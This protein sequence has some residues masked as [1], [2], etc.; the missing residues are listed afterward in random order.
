MTSE[1]I[2]SYVKF[3]DELVSSKTGKG[4]KDIEKAIIQQIL[5][6]KRLKE[7]SFPGYTSGTIQQEF[8]Y[9]LWKLLSVVTGQKVTMKT[10]PFVLEKLQKQQLAEPSQTFHPL[11]STVNIHNPCKSGVIEINQP[12]MN[13][14]HD[15][16]E[17]PDVPVFYGRTDELTTLEEWIITDKCKLV[18]LLGMG[19]IGKTSLSRKLVDKLIESSNEFQCIIWRSLRESPPIEKILTD[20]IKFLS[21][22]QITNLPDSLDEKITLLITC[23]NSSRCLL[24]LDN[25]ESILQIGNQSGQYRE[26]YQGY[27]Q[28]LSRVGESRHQSC[29]L[30][31]SREK[32]IEITTIEGVNRPIRSLQVAGLQN[33]ARQ[34]IREKSLYGSEE[35]IYK[36]TEI[37]SGNPLALNLAANAIKDLF[38]GNITECILEGTFLFNGIIQML[39]EQ[40]N[41]LSIIQKSIMYWLAINR[42]PVSIT[43]LNEDIIPISPN[44]KRVIQNALEDL[45]RRSLIESVTGC[46]TLQNFVMEYMTD[47]LREQICE[48][49][50]NGQFE[51]F[52]SHPLI[53]A[54]AKDYVRETQ[55]RLIL[56]PV[57]SSLSDVETQLM[58]CLENVRNQNKFK[59]G[60][61][62]GN[63]LNLLCSA[64]VNLH[65][66]N[67]SD[68]TIKQAYLQGQSLHNVNFTGVDF[69][70]CVFTDTIS[71]ILSVAFSPNESLVAAGDANGKVSL[72]QLAEAKPILILK[73]HQAWV[74]SIAFSPDGKMIASGSEDQTIRLWDKLTGECLWCC[75]AHT[76][77][78]RSIT[79]SPNGK[80]I[81][82]GS[83]DQTIKLWDIKTKECLQTLHGH[84]R[85]V[86]S[87]AF[88]PD[89][90]TLASG[91][92]DKTVKL[93][94]VSTGKSLITL[95][96]HNDTVN[97]VAF[98]PE[99]TTIVSGSWD[100][101][102]KL[103]NISQSECLK[104]W[105]G[106]CNSIKSVIFNP[107]NTSIISCSHDYT[108]R[109]WNI[110]TG[111]CLKVLQKHYDEAKTATLSPDGQIIAVS[112][113][114]QTVKLWNIFTTECVLTLP[115]HSDLIRLFNFSLDGQI[116][117]C[118][119]YKG[120]V[121]LWDIRTGECLKTLTTHT[122]LTAAV[123]SSNNH[124]LATS[125]GEGI[126][127]L[128]NIRTG[129]CLKTLTA[130]S[131]WV[132]SLVFSPDNKILFSASDDATIKL[133]D[134][135]TG[136][137]L[138]ILRVHT[139]GIREIA[140]NPNG[141]TIASAS[142]DHTVKLS[143]INTGKCLRI[144]EG[145]TNWVLSVA[146]SPDGLML[147]SGS[148]DETIRLWDVETGE[149]RQILRAPRHYEGMNITGVTGLT[150]ASK[151][152]LKAL[153]A[154]ELD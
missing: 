17:A 105:Q 75:Q 10:L 26:G 15:W 94:D 148:Q 151:A 83:D 115:K 30:I 68:L 93:W 58:K 71:M 67:F 106:Y 133:W 90:K 1:E 46:F 66:Y 50:R 116:L 52:N 137:C 74:Q 12:D 84:L 51:N 65:N 38:D 6:G 141:T 130:H 8:A 27:S 82:S 95:Q 41:R 128:W 118:G 102:V 45:K 144:L 99:G 44:S 119:G 87:V 126:V 60:Y 121:K 49:I 113:C 153:G 77:R 13:L 108:V 70:K 57:A 154:V 97:S 37:Y 107:Q 117:A 92:Y 11:K 36:L 42:E 55:M 9:K 110:R 19:G 2:L 14:R 122:D 139:S 142:D 123:F 61:V 135:T 131:Q 35:E 111:Q 4:L 152:T 109:P 73:G 28:L 88:S 101:T 48:E 85:W 39:D 81:A 22:Q 43:E 145:H 150:E 54:L 23:L 96:G 47:K 98:N 78:V 31:T 34:I 147:V 18:V 124:I 79:F 63:I 3:A 56:K 143:D 33:V 125:N 69:S 62:V 103:W 20:S 7:I 100:C 16:G 140:L 24:V 112:N 127:K 5:A 32:P 146:F 120:V 21:S 59:S 53:K 72:W 136:E 138:K 132:A 114:D 91:S 29:L 89:G 129:E 40:F 86:M 104:T 64:K 76:G 149:C 80:I 134:V 25:A